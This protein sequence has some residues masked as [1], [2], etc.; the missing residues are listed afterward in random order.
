MNFDVPVSYTLN[1]LVGLLD[2]EQIEHNIFRGESRDIGSGSVYGGQA[3]AQALVAAGRTVD[4]DRHAHSMHG[5]FILPGDVEAPIVYEVDR[6]RDG[7]SFT[8]RR[9][10]A[11]QHGRP[12]FNMSASFHIH[13]EGR[14]H[15]ADMPNVPGPNALPSERDLIREIADRIPERVRPFY[16][17]ER[18]IEFRPINP[19]NPF[20]PDERAPV[21]HRWFRAQGSLSDAPLLHQAV[22]AYASDYGLLT[23]ALLPHALSFVQPNLQLAT[24]DH[25]VWYHRPFRADEWL[26]YTTD[27]PAAAGSRGFS[28][29]QIFSQ[30]GTLVASVTQEGLM[31]LWDDT[32]PKQKDAERLRDEHQS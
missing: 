18:P 26:L 8:T 16:T 9:V 25:A 20:D 6:I 27:S 22:L 14:T 12:I 4:D 29:G 28:R 13:E 17:R 1:D 7:R 21:K 10:V 2:L 3:L 32:G 24:L 5:Y 31:R 30:D 23:T 19:V 11:I 15:Q